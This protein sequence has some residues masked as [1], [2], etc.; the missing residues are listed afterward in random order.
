VV[1]PHGRA[2]GDASGGVELAGGD[3]VSHGQHAT[4]GMEAE[5][6]LGHE[7]KQIVRAADAGNVIGCS[8]GEIVAKF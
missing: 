7:V 4:A 1:K 6:A 8:A 5:S 2:V 3:A